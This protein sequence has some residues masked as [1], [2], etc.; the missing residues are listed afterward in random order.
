MLIQLL[1]GDILVPGDPHG[2]AEADRRH[3]RSR[4]SHI[5]YPWG[6]DQLAVKCPLSP[7]CRD[8]PGPH[9]HRSPSEIGQSIDY[10]SSR[11]LVGE[12]CAS[13]CVGPGK[14]SP[15]VTFSASLAELLRTRTSN[16]A[17]G[18]FDTFVSPGINGHQARSPTVNGPSSNTPYPRS[19]S[20]P[21]SGCP[22][23]FQR[24]S[25]PAWSAPSTGRH[26]LFPGNHDEWVRASAPRN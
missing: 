22:S 3:L 16:T 2:A 19:G 23:H 12:I 7:I 26:W 17:A 9:P 11:A 5:P 10:R 21:S 20:A 14:L 25:C 24:R 4:P 15:R 13:A 1:A 8:A 18:V 6:A